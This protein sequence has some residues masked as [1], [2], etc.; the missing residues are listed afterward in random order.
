ME[1][2]GRSGDSEKDFGGKV[3]GDVGR[4]AGTTED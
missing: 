4:N 3:S 2:E 1:K